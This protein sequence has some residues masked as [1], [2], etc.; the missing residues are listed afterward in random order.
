MD[1]R[2]PQRPKW[3]GKGWKQVRTALPLRSDYVCPDHD[4][5]VQHHM[6]RLIG[7]AEPGEGVNVHCI[8]GRW[9]S[10]G[11]IWHGTVRGLWEHHL[12]QAAGEEPPAHTMP[13]EARAAAAR[14]L[15][16]PMNR[17][18]TL[19]CAHCS[20][21]NG[22]RCR[23]VV[24]FWPCPTAAALDGIEHDEQPDP[25]VDHG[26]V[27][28]GARVRIHLE[29][30]VEYV[31]D[32]GEIALTGGARLDQLDRRAVWVLA[33]GWK[34]GDIVTDKDGDRLVRDVHEGVEKWRE[35]KTGRHIRD[36]ETS[37]SALT[38]VPTE[39]SEES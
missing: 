28:A 33:A 35:E 7:S 5:L 11:D 8:C 15:H 36:D 2:I 25:S 1:S 32:S 31:S 9:S 13:P 12:L 16:Q 24:T 23:G 17:D 27:S 14:A 37:L 20:G 18:R 26:P 30:T 3:S 4:G 29:D 39:G 38:R 22:V 21:W 34:V 6:P 10:T 19:I